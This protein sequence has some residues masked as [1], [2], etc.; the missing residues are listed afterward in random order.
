MCKEKGKKKMSE[1]GTNRGES[2]RRKSDSEK[3]DEEPSRVKSASAKKALT[4]EY[5]CIMVVFTL[6]SLI[7]QVRAICVISIKGNCPK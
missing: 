7:A 3:S 2:D 5:Q 1:Y 6:S 4:V